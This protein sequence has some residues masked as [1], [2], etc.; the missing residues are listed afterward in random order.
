M[1]QPTVVW[2]QQ[3][4]AELN[5]AWGRFEEY[6]R[7]RLAQAQTIGAMLSEQKRKVGHGHW[8][9]WVKENCPFGTER[10]AD[11]IRVYLHRD[12]LKSG[13]LAGFEEALRYLT[14]KSKARRLTGVTGLPI[15]PCTAEEIAELE[16][17]YP[18]PSAD[19][20]PPD[21]LELHTLEGEIVRLHDDLE[22][23]CW[24]QLRRAAKVGDTLS[25]LEALGEDVRA[26]AAAQGMTWTYARCCMTTAKEYDHLR[27]VY[28]SG[29]AALD[30][31]GLEAARAAAD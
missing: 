28:K 9:K 6:G 14:E 13:H 10:A 23:A 17:L 16:R 11:F 8:E 30:A 4:R 15:G 29:E 19:S 7:K 20:D 21:P 31:S 24:E 12:E 27:A 25:R 18:G 22:A 1:G 3:M 5:A 2:T 26:I